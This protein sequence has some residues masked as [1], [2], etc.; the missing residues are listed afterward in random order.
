LGSQH[1]LPI[2]DEQLAAMDPV[3]KADILKWEQ[4][5]EKK[6]KSADLEI[7]RLYKWVKEHVVR[8]WIFLVDGNSR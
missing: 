7:A 2:T 6:C 1:Q 5:V 4:K 8:K 3:D